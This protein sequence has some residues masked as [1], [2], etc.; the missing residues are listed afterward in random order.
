LQLIVLS[1]LIPAILLGDPNKTDYHQGRTATHYAAEKGHLECLKMLV[2][3]GARYD[4]QDADGKTCLDVATPG[5]KK[6][7]ERISKSKTMHACPYHNPRLT[8]KKLW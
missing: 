5:G 8:S 3:A 4:I 6:I 7:F 1:L 2:D